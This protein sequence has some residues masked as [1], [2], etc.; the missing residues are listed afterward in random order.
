MLYVCSIYYLYFYFLNS[1]FTLIFYRY[2]M[3]PII[4]SLYIFSKTSWALPAPQTSSSSTRINLGLTSS[5]NKFDV[6][7]KL[8]LLDPVTN[9]KLAAIAS[10][11]NQL[12][13]F[14]NSA[15]H[16]LDMLDKVQV[17]HL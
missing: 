1:V 6:T 2:R 17:Q 14:T 11:A 13:D 15:S 16:Q 3:W 7:S 12:G 4:I 9:Q 10:A 5:V 8:A